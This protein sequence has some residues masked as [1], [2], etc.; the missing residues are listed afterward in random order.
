MIT[1][2]RISF[3]F[4][5]TV[6]CF[7]FVLSLQYNLDKHGSLAKPAAHIGG[8]DQIDYIIIGHTFAKYGLIAKSYDDDLASLYN[9]YQA[10][11]PEFDLT[12]KEKKWL[13]R[14][15]MMGTKI[16]H[17]GP[18][19]IAYRDWLYPLLIGSTLKIFGYSFTNLRLINIILFSLSCA[20]LAYLVAIRLGV[21]AAI[22]AVAVYLN[23]SKGLYYSSVLLSETTGSFLTLAL[24]AQLLSLENKTSRKQFFGLGITLGLMVWAKKLFFIPIAIM[25]MCACIYLLIQRK[26]RIFDYVLQV[27]FPLALMV[28]VWASYNVATTR[29]IGF[30]TGSNGWHDMPASWSKEMIT[31]DNMGAYHTRREKLFN[32][33]SDFYKQPIIGH[34]GRASF[35]KKYFF[36]VTIH[37]TT[38]FEKLLIIKQK[39]K[40]ELKSSWTLNLIR[41]LALVWIL[42]GTEALWIRLTCCLLYFGAFV[43]VSLVHG[44]E[45]RLFFN[46]DIASMALAT[47][48]IHKLRAS[49]QPLIKSFFSPSD[50]TDQL[51]NVDSTS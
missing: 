44:D 20:L 34:V 41:I 23:F 22:A 46:L 4:S 14:V 18:T 10:K 45:G 32:K 13:H 11:S 5:I 50:Q 8:N 15:G 39:L 37:Q 38:P 16:R 49:F 36:D 31:E 33:I 24:I 25:G 26:P 40:N 1:R 29:A 28:G 19:P 12:P 35:G 48:G 30:I 9:Q 17:E 6:L 21:F 27:I 3:I 7:S 43:S 2:P 47:L 42:M 51:S